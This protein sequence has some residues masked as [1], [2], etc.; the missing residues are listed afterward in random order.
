MNE[1]KRIL[2]VD[3]EPMIRDVLEM[4]L[5][6]RGYQVTACSDGGIALETMRS[7]PGG[8]DLVLTDNTMPRMCGTELARTLRKEGYRGPI[9]MMTADVRLL[10]NG[11]PED[12]SVL[13]SKPSDNDT[14]VAE[15]KR[16]LTV[17]E[18]LP[19]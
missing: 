17:H 19:S 15:I 16:L 10:L 12:I 13:L 3:D 18:R 14:I 4:L 11:A 5:R 1:N 9:I 7:T 2:V 8:Y 6:R